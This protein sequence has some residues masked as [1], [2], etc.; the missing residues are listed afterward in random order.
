MQG[1]KSVPSRYDGVFP[2]V[3]IDV[4]VTTSVMNHD[5]TGA[6]PEAAH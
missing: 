6:V 4:P 5:P 2:L 1:K 3:F